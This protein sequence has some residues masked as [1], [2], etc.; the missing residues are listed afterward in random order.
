MKRFLK[1]MNL[2]V[3]LPVSTL[4]AQ[5]NQ[6]LEN[7]NL[8]LGFEFGANEVGCKLSEHERIRKDNRS[9]NEFLSA[10]SYSLTTMYWGIKP[11]FFVLNNRMGIASGLRFTKA[12]SELSSGMEKFLWKVEEEGFYTN[13]VQLDKLRQKTY[14]LTVPFEIRYFLNDRELPFQTYVKAGM[15]V[16]YRIRSE[17][18]VNFWN[19]AME[20][21]KDLVQSQLSDNDNFFSSFAF[22]A[23]GFKIGK[24][25]EES[26]MPWVNVEFQ[27]PYILL[28]NNSFSFVKRGVDG[29][30][31][32]GFQ[33]FFQIPIGENVPIGSN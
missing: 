8:K 26:P 17:N 29:L 25:R 20:S 18:H 32:F 7:H 15:S 2:L 9:Y 24:F 16:N 5:D 3:L 12:T 1:T 4:F 33:L 27:F 19:S 23:I 28:T 30:A 22:G 11:E 21:N 13:Y 10:R 31:G 14:L 6:M